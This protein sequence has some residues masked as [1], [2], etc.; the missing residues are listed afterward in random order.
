MLQDAEGLFSQGLKLLDSEKC[1]KAVKLFKEVVE[2]T[3]DPTQIS[4][5]WDSL[6]EIDFYG[7]ESLDKRID[8]MLYYTE[9]G[10]L[11]SSGAYVPT[12]H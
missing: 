3:C 11:I 8:T 4:R 12:S 9:M 5:A 7:G 2:S 6:D 10:R 1:I